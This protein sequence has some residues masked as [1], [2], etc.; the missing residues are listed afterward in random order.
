MFLISDVV[1]YIIAI[2]VGGVTVIVTVFVIVLL[3]TIAV[4][5]L[6]SLWSGGC[7]SEK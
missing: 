7:R 3:A 1:I 6:A 4:R 2:V 5:F